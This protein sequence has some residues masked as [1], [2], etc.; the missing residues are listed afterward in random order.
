MYNL[1]VCHSQ[2]QIILAVGLV[3]GRFSA[4]KNDIIIFQ[5]FILQKDIRESI[6]STFNSVLMRTGIYPAVNSTWKAKINRYPKDIIALSKF[7]DKPY[8]KVFVVCDGN[9]PELYILKNSRK[10]KKDVEMIWLEDGSYPYYLN[11]VAK[12]GLN[13]NNFSRLLRKFLFKYL[14]RL[15]SIYDFEGDFMGAN[16]NLKKA[17]LTFKGKERDIF[18]NKEIIGIT[19]DEYIKGITTLFK[20][21][22]IKVEDNSIILVLDKLDTYSTL[23]SVETMVKTIKKHSINRNINL[24]FKYHPREEESLSELHIGATEL[25][26][27]LA[28]EYYYSGA[29]GRKISVIGVKSTG[30]QS[31]LVLGFNSI[32]AIKI[33]EE[34]SEGIINFYNSIGV[35]IPS[36]LSGLLSKI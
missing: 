5:D 35:H 13:S 33:I 27:D 29:I 18:N 26:K 25:K 31:S 23:A 6:M 9:I 34:K 11:V 10:L 22:G 3:K 30:L 17:Y 2:A 8:D 28:I 12:D 24:Y 16:T 14:F 15:G 21:K 19:K 1:F 7:M 20:P 4:H 32:S 36:D